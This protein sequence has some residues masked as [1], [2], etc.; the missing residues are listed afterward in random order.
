M[1]RVLVT[2]GAGYIGSVCSAELLQ[3]GHEVVVVDD[4]STGHR[5]AVPTQARFYD[6]DIGDRIAMR[7]IFSETRVES[8]FHFA[9][10]ALISES[11]TN[12]GVFFERNLAAGI[13]LCEATRESGVKHFVFSSTAAVYGDPSTVPIPEEHPTEPVNAY[14]E[15]KLGFERALRW[16]ASAY[17]WTVTSFRYFNACGSTEEQGE[18]HDP[19]T[20]ILPLLLQVA[21]GRR[22]Y[23]EIYGTDYDTPD[24]TCLRDYVHVSDIADAHLL[25]LEQPETPGF[26]AYNIG[27]GTSYSVQ[28]VCSTVAAVTG[29]KLQLRNAPRRL[30]DPAVLCA[31]PAKLISR[32]GWRPKRSSLTAIVESA[33]Q[34]E[35]RQ[36]SLAAAVT[37]AQAQYPQN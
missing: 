34:W 23:F 21:S 35:R 11:V 3:R 27:T 13:Q 10:K 12:P 25:A 7:R 26:H 14:G 6:A 36:A 20:H 18:L 31:S 22:V 8:V 4:L 15:S 29:R 33:W 9:A 32:F 17:G 1:A 5:D 24:G 28:Q 30:G 16:Y 19:E 37:G 2:G